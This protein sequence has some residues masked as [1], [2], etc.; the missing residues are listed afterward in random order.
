M[1]TITSAETVTAAY[2]QLMYRS[3]DG[4][5]GLPA[6]VVEKPRHVFKQ[7][8]LRHPG[9][10]HAHDFMKERTSCVVKSPSLS[11]DGEWLAR[12]SAAYEIDLGEFIGVD[13]GCVTT[14]IYTSCSV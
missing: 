14:E 6:V 2:G 1:L 12:K 3:D 11:A 9:F 8:I 4:A 5:E 7:K 13:S 10:S